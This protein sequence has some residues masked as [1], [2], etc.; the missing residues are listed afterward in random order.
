MK[1]GCRPRDQRGASAV[2]FALISVVFFTLL[3]GMVQYSF[4]FWSSQSAANAAR[5]A[6]RRGAVGQTC[7]DMLARTQSS[8]KLV[9]SGLTVV[10]R[11]Y[12]PTDTS[13]STPV[14]AATGNNVRVELSYDSVD[15]HFPFV[16]FLDDGRVRETAVSRVEN[17][18]TQIPSNWTDCG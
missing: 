5:E 11:Y 12:L 4:Y 16:P 6:A 18:S 8:T 10:R 2:E 1:V 14:A 9:E 7:A 13:F 17:F 3:F 15:L